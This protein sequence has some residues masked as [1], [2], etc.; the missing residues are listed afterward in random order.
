MPMLFWLPIIFASAWWEMSGFPPQ[1]LANNE[2]AP[3]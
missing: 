3:A 2:Q 1:A